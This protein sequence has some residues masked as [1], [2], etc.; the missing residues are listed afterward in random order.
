MDKLLF[1][2]DDIIVSL[3]RFCNKFNKYKNKIDEFIEVINKDYL[4]ESRKPLI[5]KLHQKMTLLKFI[6]N[7]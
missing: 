2:Q 6:I 7:K 3:D 5:L 4:L 1:D